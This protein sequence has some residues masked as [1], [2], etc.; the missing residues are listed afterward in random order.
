MTAGAGEA[1]AR[2]AARTGARAA[3]SAG[4]PCWSGVGGL[5]PDAE[6]CA[7]PRSVR[8]VQGLHVARGMC[9]ILHGRTH[10][11]DVTLETLAGLPLSFVSESG[12]VL[13]LSRDR[14]SAET[15]PCGSRNLVSHISRDIPLLSPV[16]ARNSCPISYIRPFIPHM[17]LYSAYRFMYLLTV[18]LNIYLLHSTLCL[19]LPRVMECSEWLGL[20]CVPGRF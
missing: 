11:P 15:S 12:T 17:I 13:T 14:L 19:T 3:M 7:P 8:S 10:L 6:R 4:A 9:F 20:E 1:Q 18:S 16:A 5:S 2:S